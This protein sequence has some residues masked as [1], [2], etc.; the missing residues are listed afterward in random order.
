[1][2]RILRPGLTPSVT[3]KT[4]EAPLFNPAVFLATAAAGRDISKYSK[5]DTIFTQGDEAD[6]LCPQR[7]D[8]RVV[9][10]FT[11]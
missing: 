3:R 9:P 11:S 10:Q 7:A 1:M 4:A 6:A 5:K 8:A 2:S